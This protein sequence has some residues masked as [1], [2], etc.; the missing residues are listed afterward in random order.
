MT[1]FELFCR[2]CKWKGNLRFLFTL[3]VRMELKSYSVFI[4]KNVFELSIFIDSAYRD[5]CAEN[6]YLARL[7]DL[8]FVV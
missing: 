2:L 6:N 7:Y 5:D 1:F 3:F 4:V 8:S